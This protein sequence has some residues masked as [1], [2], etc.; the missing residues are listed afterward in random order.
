MNKVEIKMPFIA[1]KVE[2][3]KK[4]KTILE[5]ISSSRTKAAN[6]IQRSKIILQSSEGKNNNDI[7]KA[8]VIQDGKFK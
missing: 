5:K 4:T 6:Q 8:A 1:S 2:I 3:P 7:G